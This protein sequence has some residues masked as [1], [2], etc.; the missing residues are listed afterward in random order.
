MS[1]ELHMNSKI[2]RFLLAK[3]L[4]TV[5]SPINYKCYSHW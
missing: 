4:C 1:E 3:D 5:K 2:V